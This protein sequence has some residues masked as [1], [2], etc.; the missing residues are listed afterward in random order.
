MVTLTVLNGT[1]QHVFQV[2]AGSNLR[3]VLLDHDLSPYATLTQRANCGGRGL[4]ATCGVWLGDAPEP[5][6]WHDKLANQ[7]GY[8]RLSCQ[9][10]LEQDLTVR[11][12]PEK[13]IWGGRRK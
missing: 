12:I 10:T 6:H 13:W 1:V 5:T 11:L 8:P 4:C 3:R 7:F 2:P 9:I